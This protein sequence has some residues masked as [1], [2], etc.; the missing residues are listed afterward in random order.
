MQIKIKEA[1]I[2][3]RLTGTVTSRKIVISI[4]NGVLKA[5]DPNSLP[6]FGGWIALTDN[7][8]RWVLDLWT[9]LISNAWQLL[10]IT[11]QRVNK[12]ANVPKVCQL[13]NLA[14][15]CAKGVAIFQLR[16]PKG[17]PIFQLFFKRIFQFF[18]FSIMFTICKF[19]EYLDNSRKLISRNEEFK[20]WHLQN[21]IKVKPCQPK[22]FDV[23]VN[24]AR[25]FNRIIIRL[26]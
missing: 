4:G 23:L 9:G 6:E 17:V 18:N 26:V 15:Q 10:I 7:W 22:T 5:N 13:F 25:G 16:L 21:F 12:R 3:M 2:G 8:A 20:F 11:C 19:Q 1:I 14:C 24:R